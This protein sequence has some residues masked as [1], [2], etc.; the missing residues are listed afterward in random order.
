[1]NP[2]RVS[3]TLDSSLE[4]VNKA[5][6]AASG[7][8][9]R[10]GFAEEQVGGISMAVR[11]AAINAVQHGNH[12][13]PSKRMSVLFES[14]PQGLTVTVR[15]EGNGLDPAA[16]PDPLASENLLRQSGRGIFL[17][18]AFMDRVEINRLQHGTEIVLTKYLQS[19]GEEGKENHP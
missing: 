4:S 14:A 17:M 19:G 3:Y 7:A 13:D 8:A 16:I 5:E 18:R 6:Q 15:D 12:Y 10:C 11:E 1:M 9:R 2:T